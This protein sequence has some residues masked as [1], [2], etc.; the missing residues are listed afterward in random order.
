MIGA[1]ALAG[2]LVYAAKLIRIPARVTTEGA[3]KK[4]ATHATVGLYP[5]CGVKELFFHIRPDI[6]EQDEGEDQ[7]N[8]EKVEKQFLDAASV[9]RVQV[10][11]R[12]F[13]NSGMEGLISGDN[14]G[15]LQPV[16]VEYWRSATL[17]HN[18]YSDPSP[19]K[20]A[21]TFPRLNAKNFAPLCDLQVN[22]AQAEIVWPGPD[23]NTKIGVT[24]DLSILGV[25]KVHRNSIR[26]IERISVDDND[27]SHV[28]IFFHAPMQFQYIVSAEGN[29]QVFLSVKDTKP[30]SAIF[31]I[32]GPSNLVFLAAI[33]VTPQA[34][35]FPR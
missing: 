6:L 12:P 21:H 20:S 29:E 31:T 7:A 2:L 27:P 25:A 19:T 24:V 4:P 14:S 11:G 22:R 23:P 13:D 33:S 9:G 35:K 3:Q 15:P 32:R 34:T 5:D 28:E 30:E 17:S 16:P 26:G 10:W 8:W 18:F 1:T